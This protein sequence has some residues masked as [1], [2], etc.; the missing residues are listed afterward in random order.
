MTKLLI[1]SMALVSGVAMA[2]IVVPDG[3]ALQL[4]LQLLTQ[5]SSLSPLAI[6]S[7]LIVI[8][9][10]VLKMFAGDFKFKRLAVVLL[11]CIYAVIQSRIQGLDIGNAVVLMLISSG[12][13]VALFE[14]I[15]PLI[16]DKA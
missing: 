11:G 5:W 7:I 2:S 12:G 8:A 14:A 1:A 15:K 13:A 16:E 3:D 9:M 4:L 6:G 10:Q